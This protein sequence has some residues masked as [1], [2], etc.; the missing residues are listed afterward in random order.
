MPDLAGLTL[1]PLPQTG[2]ENRLFRLGS[3]LL[4]FP[5]NALAEAQI[6]TLQALLPQLDLPFPLPRLH[7]LGRPGGGYPY[8]WALTDWLPGCPAPELGPA[9][10]RRLA[11]WV[12]ALRSLSPLPGAPIRPPL[13]AKLVGLDRLV[14]LVTE[15]PPQALWPLLDRALAIAPLRG[16]VWEHGDLHGL[17][18]LGQRGRL[19]GLI[20]WGSLAL[21]DGSADLLPAFMA[22][23]LP[24][25][26]VFLDRMAPTQGQV[27]RGFALA[28]QKCLMGLPAYRQSNPVFAGLLRQSLSRL[29][30]FP[31]FP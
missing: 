23:D 19:C 14:P 2:T 20:D 29:L 1:R 3:G 7:R 26:L 16:Q 31:A 5:R 9:E 25:A 4:R 8:H 6:L 11:D 15:A 13:E 28:L 10:A 21:G 24:A 18:L 12:L 17:N 22:L 30:A 27:E